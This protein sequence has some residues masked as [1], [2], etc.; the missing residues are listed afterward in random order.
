MFLR[1][2]ITHLRGQA[3]TTNANPDRPI[4]GVGSADLMS[5]VLA[6]V[7]PHAALL[8]GLCSPQVVRTAH[9]ADLAAVVFVRGKTPDIEVIELAQAEGIPLITT[10]LGMYEACGCLFQAGFVSLEQPALN[11]PRARL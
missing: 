3:L 7:Q 11:H 2:L 8:T 6:C 10:P 5:D 1:D 4:N 9:M